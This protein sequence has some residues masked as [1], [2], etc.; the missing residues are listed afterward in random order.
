VA[1]YPLI[2]GVRADWGS[3]EITINDKIV[4]GVKEISYTPT[5]EPGKGRGTSA[6]L[7]FRTRGQQDFEASVTLFH[8]EGRELM[9]ALGD[10]FMEVPF[11]ITVSY[12]EANL[13][14][15]TDTLVGCRITKVEMSGSE[16]S[17]PLVFK[18]SLSIIDLLY[19]GVSG[20]KTSTV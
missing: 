5:L 14:A 19:N 12:S 1:E 6:R 3:V 2:N 18:L 10:G 17:D 8:L 16:G 11:Q 4:T 20:L 7:N 9:A 15:V 13:P